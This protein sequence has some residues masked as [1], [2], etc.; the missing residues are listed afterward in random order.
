MVQE[1]P[2]AEGRDA[3]V[4]APDHRRADRHRARARGRVR[5]D[6]VLRRLDRRDLPAVLD[7]DRVGDDAV[8]AHRADPDAG[9]VRDDAE[10][11]ARRAPLDAAARSAGSTA[12]SARARAATT[13][14]SR[15]ACAGPRGCSRSTPSVIAA[16]ALLYARLPT[17][18]IPDEDA[19]ILY[20]QVQAPP[21]ASQER[22]WSR[23]RRGAGLLPR[24]RRATSS[25]ACSRSSA[26]TSPA[27]AR[28]P[29]SCS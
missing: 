16:V 3:Q 15:S 29:A 22:T 9:A 26:S 24:P 20:G 18:F 21:G 10:A 1:R 14:A 27:P 7:H 12:R 19:G 8:G 13:A 28:T 17:S 25:T 6:G 2:V 4:D 5:A 11:S 23:A